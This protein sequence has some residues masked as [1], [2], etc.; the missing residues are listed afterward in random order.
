M[1]MNERPLILVGAGG[2]AKEVAWAVARMNAVSPAFR[3]LGFCDDAPERQ[4]GE[5]FG[6]PLLG[7]VE[8][9]AERFAAEGVRPC[10]HCAVGD[11]ARRKELAGRAL[12]AGWEPASVIDPSVLIAPGVEIGAGSYVGVGCVLSADVRIGAF[13]LLNFQVTVGHDAVLGAYVQVCPGVRIS[14]WCEIGEG[15]LLGSNAV[16]V[17]KRRMGAWSVLGA[18]TVA[19]RDVPEKE[20]V[21]R[22]S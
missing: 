12:K 8:R 22:L 9:A 7:P 17:Q 11:N 19:F 6:L 14:G 13:A 16:I 20:T 21:V 1:M 18:G 3:V 2:L 4:A 10:F 15:A 5:W